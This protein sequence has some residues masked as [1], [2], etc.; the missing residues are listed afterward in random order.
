LRVFNHFLIKHDFSQNSPYMVWLTVYF[1]WFWEKQFVRNEWLQFFLMGDCA[2][3]EI[4]KLSETHWRVNRYNM[5][6]YILEDR[7]WSDD[8]SLLLREQ[9]ICYRPLTELNDE[10]QHIQHL[11]FWWNNNP[12]RITDWEIYDTTM[13]LQ[14]YIPILTIFKS[15]FS[16]I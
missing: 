15:N 16:Q 4:L 6:A 5:H 12:Q 1:I 14:E 3:R 7:P 13:Q 10:C 8:P 2:L 9:R 11:V